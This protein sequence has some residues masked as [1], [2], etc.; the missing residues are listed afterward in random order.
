M[1]LP[2]T[3]KNLSNS[4][5]YVLSLLKDN[6][7]FTKFLALGWWG[8]EETLLKCLAIPPAFLTP[9]EQREWHMKSSCFQ[10]LCQEGTIPLQ[11]T[12]PLRK[13]TKKYSA[14][15]SLTSKP[16]WCVIESL[17]LMASVTLGLDPPQLHDIGLITIWPHPLSLSS[18]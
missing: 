11:H 2:S 1:G 3:Q 6:A 4:K 7:I 5:S 13:S 16:S 14:I 9:E 17:M 15:C 10:R 18:A 12:T 8:S